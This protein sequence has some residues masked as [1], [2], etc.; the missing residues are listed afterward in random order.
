[1]NYR[2]IK[3]IKPSTREGKKLMVT[4]KSGRK[5]KTIHFGQKGYRN[6]YSKKAW[7]SYMQRSAGIRDKNGKLTKDNPFSANFWA[8]KKLW[9]G[10]KWR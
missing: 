5:T 10:A 4:I 7:K 8:R 2:I 1:M 6:N 9:N 3:P